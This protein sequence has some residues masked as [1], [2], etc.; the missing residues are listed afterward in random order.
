METESGKMSQECGEVWRAKE[1]G[2]EVQR[3]MNN[4]GP[5]SRSDARQTLSRKT[6]VLQGQRDGTGPEW[7]GH[8]SL[9]GP[10]TPF[11]LDQACRVEVKLLMGSCRHIPSYLTL[12]L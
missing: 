1:D 4:R 3:H 5:E 6:V 9:S 10:W 7:P 12:D 2:R 8:V 11:G